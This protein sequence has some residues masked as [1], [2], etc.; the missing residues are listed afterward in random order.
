MLFST[1]LEATKLNQLLSA[2][3]F[4]SFNTGACKFAL[5]L[6]FLR[7]KDN[8]GFLFAGGF[9]IVLA[10]LVGVVA[11]SGSSSNIDSN[12]ALWWSLQSYPSD[13]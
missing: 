3:E 2:L 12:S 6:G 9:S 10:L 11:F 13:G 8:L 5:S 7:D 4:F 1:S